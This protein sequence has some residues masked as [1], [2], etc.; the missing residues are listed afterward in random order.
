MERISLG[1]DPCHGYVACGRV[2]GK[3]GAGDDHMG[4]PL[5]AYASPPAPPRIVHAA[6]EVARLYRILEG[7]PLSRRIET[8]EPIAASAE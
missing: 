1:L 3:T 5:P 6:D 4:S 7:T 2:A 8:I